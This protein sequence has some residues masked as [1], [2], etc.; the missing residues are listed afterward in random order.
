V[1]TPTF[2]SWQDKSLPATKYNPSKAIKTLE[3]AGFK[4]GSNGI[5]KSKSGQPLSFTIK[6]ISGFSDWDASLQ[7]ITQQLKKVGIAV[8]VQDENSGPYTSD[9]DSGHYQLAYA[10]SGG[11][12]PGA[13]PSPYYELRGYLFGGNV[14]STNYERYNS[15]ST[16]ALF[17]QYA[18]DSAS[19]QV[20]VIHKIEKVMVKDV[21]FIPVTEG[22]DWFQYNSAAFS[23]WPSA[24][25]PFARAAPYATPD[26]GVVLT[27]LSPK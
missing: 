20:Q 1:I 13:G 19:K 7:L 23:G 15:K 22:V 26:M 6:T 24:S 11:P 17:N 8:T 9:L 27:H 14:G 16:D 18:G 25:D 3:A 12:A 5:F 10:G 4:R 2:D 21:P